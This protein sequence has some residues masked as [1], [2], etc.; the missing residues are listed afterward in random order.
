MT[1]TLPPELESLIRDKA[2]AEGLTVDAY[3]ERLIRE[4]EDWGECRDKPLESTDPEFQEIQ[5]AIAEGLEQ[6]D[7]GESWPAQEIFSELR[8]K[9]GISR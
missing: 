8:A 5:A 1:I 7:R 2:Q 9:Y 3:V 6:A 4:D